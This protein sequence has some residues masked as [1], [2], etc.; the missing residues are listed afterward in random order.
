LANAISIGLAHAGDVMGR[1][2]VDDDHVISGLRKA[3]ATAKS[4]KTRNF[5]ACWAIC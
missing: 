5:S 3:S 4:E 2:V 1:E